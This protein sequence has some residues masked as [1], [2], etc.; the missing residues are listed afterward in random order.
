MRTPITYYG[1]KQQ[2][3]SRIIAMMPKHRIYCEPF[4]GGGAVFFAKPKGYLEVINDKNDRLITF[5]HV[6]QN[7]FDELADMV[8]Q[9]LHSESDYLR[10][11][12]IYYD[13]TEATDIEVAWSVWILTNFSFSGSIQGGWKWCNGTAGSHTGVF[14][15]YKRNEFNE[16]LRQRLQD[17]QI[18]CRD[19][20]K[21][22][23][24]R[25]TADTFFY[26]DPPYPGCVQKHYSGYTF[27]NLE[28]LLTKLQGIKGKFILSNYNS[29]MLKE[30]VKKNN[31][32]IQQIDMPLRIANLTKA[33]R[34]VEVLVSNY[35]NEPT[36]FNE[37]I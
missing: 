36:I 32:K 35:E 29:P 5:Y 24:E 11:K 22:I 8:Q 21:V 6:C 4:F 12:S 28:E 31:W 16:K 15:R 13:R 23:Q 18:S 25:D 30:Y 2:L 37:T 14:M 33:K 9:S 10:A 3:S 34:K 27:E 19:A 7:R 1:G 20:L 26:L 17:V